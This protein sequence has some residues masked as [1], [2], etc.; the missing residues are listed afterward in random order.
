MAIDPLLYTLEKHGRGFTL[1]GPPIT[2]LAFADDLVL[3][4][5]SWSDMAGNLAVL[6]K[7]YT[8]T[9]LKVNPKKCHGFCRGISGPKYTLNDCDSWTLQGTPIHMMGSEE[10]EKYLGVQ[11]NPWK[12]VTKPL[13]Q[14]MLDGMVKKIDRASLKPSQKLE[15]FKTYAVPCL[16]C[17]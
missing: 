13:L 12:G 8:M 15:I 7:L 17:G 4:S 6:E 5:D 16:T 1:A 9:G 11:I 2:S 3:L 14:D 10:S